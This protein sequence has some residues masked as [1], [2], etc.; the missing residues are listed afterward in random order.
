M[1]STHFCRLKAPGPFSLYQANS[2]MCF[3]SANI[4]PDDLLVPLFQ[5]IMEDERN[6]TNASTFY[7]ERWLDLNL[8]PPGFVHNRKA[9]LPFGGGPRVCPG[10]MLAQNTAVLA[11]ALIYRNFKLTLVDPSPPE[12]VFNL[13]YCPNEFQI[14]FE[15][16][17]NFG[18]IN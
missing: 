6:F 1:K 14:H 4:Q 9:Y 18:N 7:P 11:V 12:R 2:Q 13:T 16:R 8:L 5:N 3:H 10:R 15:P 17:S